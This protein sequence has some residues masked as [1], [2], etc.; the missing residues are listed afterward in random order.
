VSSPRHWRLPRAATA[1]CLQHPA[2]RSLPAPTPSTRP[3]RRP[4]AASAPSRPPRGLVSRTKQSCAPGFRERR[5]SRRAVIPFSSRGGTKSRSSSIAQATL[6]AISEQLQVSPAVAHVPG[7]HH[8]PP[9]MKSP[10]QAHPNPSRGSDNTQSCNRRSSERGGADSARQSVPR[11]CIAAGWCCSHR[12]TECDP[13]RPRRRLLRSISPRAMA[14]TQGF[15]RKAGIVKANSPPPTWVTRNA[16]AGSGRMPA[17][18]PSIRPTVR[19]SRRGPKRRGIE[20]CGNRSGRP[21]VKM[22]APR[23]RAHGRGAPWN[24]CHREEW[25]WLLGS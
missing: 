24:G 18:T 6:A 10:R 15:L 4:P 14:F 25:I 7:A 8:N 19:G 20:Q 21:M 3:S 16:I 17:N 5:K 12:P 11:P 22:V 23:M 13:G 9:L 2:P 1:P